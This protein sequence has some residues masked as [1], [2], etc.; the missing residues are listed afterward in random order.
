MWLASIRYQS[1]RIFQ[2]KHKKEVL[3]SSQRLLRVRVRVYKFSGIPPEG[4]F[5]EKKEEKTHTTEN[6]RTTNFT[7]RYDEICRSRRLLTVTSLHTFDYKSLS[8]TGING[9][10]KKKMMDDSFINNAYAE[11]FQRFLKDEIFKDFSHFKISF[12]FWESLKS[13]LDDLDI[14]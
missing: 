9:G 3:I 1:L 12:F 8:A 11:D 7:I 2:T 4:P 14:V 13:N 6:G 5:D 10:E